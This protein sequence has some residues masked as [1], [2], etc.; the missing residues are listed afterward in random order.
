VVIG[1]QW[2]SLADETGVPLLQKPHDWVRREIR[3]ALRLRKHVLPVL[4]D[5]VEMPGPQ[6]LPREIAELSSLTALPVSHRRLRED[7]ESLADRLIDLVPT[8][9]R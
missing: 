9:G 1:P 3:L 7:F 2:L 6:A 8:L 5:G 4:L